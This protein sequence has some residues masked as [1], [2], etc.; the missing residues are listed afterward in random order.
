[1]IRWIHTDLKLSKKQLRDLAR[2]AGLTFGHSNMEID[3]LPFPTPYD[4]I[5]HWLLSEDGQIAIMSKFLKETHKFTISENNKGKYVCETGIENIIGKG[6]SPAD[7]VINC[8]LKC[9]K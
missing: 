4:L 3:E 5:P 2:W 7:A 9:L 6:N 1:M 8:A